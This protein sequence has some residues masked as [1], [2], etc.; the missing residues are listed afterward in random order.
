M[1]CANPDGYLW[2]NSTTPS[3]KNGRRELNAFHVI[4]TVLG[5]S[6]LVIFSCS[7]HHHQLHGEGAILFHFACKG[8]EV[9][10]GEISSPGAVAPE[11]KPAQHV[12]LLMSLYT[13]CWVMQL[14]KWNSEMQA[15]L[16]K[17][18]KH[19]P[20][21]TSQPFPVSHPNTALTLRIFLPIHFS[22]TAL[23]DVACSGT[24]FL[25]CIGLFPTLF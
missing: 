25:L 2:N 1:E 7:P 14:Q 6:Q 5:N 17:W 18:N 11:T 9:H 4:G 16:Q 8:S 24:V 10:T 15:P 13:R 12:M 22:I 19:F 3:S 20:C 21:L 23:Y